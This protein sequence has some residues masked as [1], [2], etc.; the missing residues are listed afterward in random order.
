MSNITHAV[1]AHGYHSLV[2]AVVI[3]ESPDTKSFVLDVP[4]ELSDVFSYRAGQFC[5]VRVSIE[6]DD[7]L[8]CYSM[9]SAPAVD[10]TFVITVKRVPGGVMSN[11]LHDQVAVGNALELM[12]P[13]G[14]FCERDGDV[15]FV[16][17]GGGSG[18]TPVFSILKQVLA[19]TTR[20]VRLLY[21]NRDHQSVIFAADLNRL[22]AEYP[23][24]LTV[25]HHLDSEAGYLSAGDIVDF[26]GSDTGADV[27]VCGPT[28]FMDVVEAGVAQAGVAPAQVSIERFALSG[29]PV[30]PVDVAASPADAAGA[31]TD[32]VTRSL[33]VVLKGKRYVLDYTAGDTMLDAARRGGLKPPF[34]CELGNCA[35][36]MA[37]VSEGGAT[38]RANN[39]LTPAEVTEGWVLTCQAL[40][41]GEAVV[42]EYE[43]L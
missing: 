6:G 15:P 2:V 17:F 33:T 18:I 9:S 3:D 20:A 23:D 26:V 21:A 32:D 28:P 22:A 29:G 8:R 38:M 24:R 16:A 42:V 41:M 10:Q 12:R 25:R 35:S 14:V 39:A 1:N 31:A 36:C 43:N 11:W 4:P 34:S 37:L 40:P 27:Y 5:T 19:T 13:S 7:V 30:D